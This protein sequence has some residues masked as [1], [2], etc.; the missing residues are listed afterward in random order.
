MSGYNREATLHYPEE[1]SH[2]ELN[3][4]EPRPQAVRSLQELVRQPKVRPCLILKLETLVPTSKSDLTDSFLEA[5]L[6]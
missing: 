5:L 4:V 3:V 1:D 6:F 2:P